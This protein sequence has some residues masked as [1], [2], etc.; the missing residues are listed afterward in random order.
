MWTKLGDE[1]GDAAWNL[2][3]HAFRTHTES[4]MWSNKLGLDLMIPKRHLRQYTFSDRAQDAAAELCAAGWWKDT[5]D[6]WDIG[7]RF[8]EWQLE[9]EVIEHRR[10]AN[11][12][13]Q[14]R[15]R[16]HKAGNHSLCQPPQCPSVT[17]DVTRDE[18]RDTTRDPG[19]VGTGRRRTNP[20]H[21]S[22]QRKP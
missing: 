18:T 10:A 1:Y 11:A 7:Q 4:L 16:L 8:P 19:R 13:R 15:H 22:R 21:P 14:R 20:S 3:D 12:L 6:Y 2:S 5:G 9:A 17:R